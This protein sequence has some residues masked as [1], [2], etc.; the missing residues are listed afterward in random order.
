MLFEQLTQRI[1]ETHSIFQQY[2]IK[3]VNVG[4]TVRNWLIGY[5][6]VE[7][8]QHGK[9]RAKYGEQLLEKI[10]RELSNKG[11]DNISAAELSRFRQFYFTYPQILETVS[12]KL[13]QTDNDTIIIE[14]VKLLSN[15][16]F[17]H[18]A[19]LIK[20]TDPLKRTFY[21]IECIRGT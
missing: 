13:Q 3:A 8:E 7:Y 14:P 16:S 21:E 17:S 11:I 4:L 19:E 9:D 18:F 20:I 10:T 5:Y 12:Q 2:A 15:L 6:I 1:K